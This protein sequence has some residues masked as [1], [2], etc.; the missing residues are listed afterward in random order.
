MDVILKNAHSDRKSD[1]KIWTIFG[2]E[3]TCLKCDKYLDLT[4]CCIHFI[5]M[6]CNYIV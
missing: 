4:A 6:L 2:N 5:F 3:Q 1:K